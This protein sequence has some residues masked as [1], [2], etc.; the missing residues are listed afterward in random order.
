LEKLNLKGGK[1]MRILTAELIR[2]A[3]ELVR[4]SVEKILN[5]EGTTWGPKWVEV[6]VRASDQD[7]LTSVPVLYT[8]FGKAIF[9]Q[10]EWGEKKDFNKIALSKLYVAKREGVN[11][12]IVIAT[13]P[14]K[15]KKGEYLYPGG[16][17]RDG[18]SVG[19]SGAKGVTDEAI[20]E[21][22]ISAII[23]LAQLETGQR[24]KEGKAEI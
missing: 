9:W 10:S 16:A 3:L 22:V 2:K 24:L 6:V 4:P 5:T 13:Q 11:T 14:W 18:I 23:M 17:T 7:S 15:L 12:S 8:R 19:V 20:A 1:R 21:I